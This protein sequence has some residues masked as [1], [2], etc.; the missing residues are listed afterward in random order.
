MVEVVV[1]VVS[2]SNAFATFFLAC[3]L[4]TTLCYR[5]LR[6]LSASGNRQFAGSIGYLP[7]FG[8][9]PFLGDL[10]AFPALSA[11]RRPLAIGVLQLMVIVKVRNAEP[12]KRRLLV[13]F[14]ASLFHSL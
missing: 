2:A 7:V 14:G 11:S 3:Q 8:G 10:P 12:E 6:W 5:R 4:T 13:G 1:V 9:C